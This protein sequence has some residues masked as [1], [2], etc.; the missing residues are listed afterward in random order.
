MRYK[1][2]SNLRAT[3][4]YQNTSVRLL[5]SAERVHLDGSRGFFEIGRDYYYSPNIFLVNFSN[6]VG[7]AELIVD[8]E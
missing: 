4:N 7:E 1:V 8:C 3:V 6:E 2:S 5:G